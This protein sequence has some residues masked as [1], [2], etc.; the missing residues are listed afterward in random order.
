MSIKV[1][2]TQGLWPKIRVDVSEVSEYVSGAGDDEPKGGVNITREKLL[3][4]A[5]AFK[6]SVVK[7]GCFCAQL[8]SDDELTSILL[9]AGRELANTFGVLCTCMTAV[10]LKGGKCL[11]AEV[12]ALGDDINKQ[13]DNLNMAALA[14]RASVSRICGALLERIQ[15]VKKMSL[16]P[17]SACRKIVIRNIKCM[18]D[19]QDELGSS[20]ERVK[21]GKK[22]EG[23]VP[24]LVDDE[25]DVLDFDGDDDLFL[26][27][28][29][30]E[31][32][33]A[34]EGLVGDMKRLA[35]SAADDIL[36]ERSRKVSS[37]IDEIVVAI[38]TGS[39]D[40]E[41]FDDLFDALEREGCGERMGK[42]REIV[43]R[44]MISK[45]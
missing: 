28:S 8:Q 21:E 7:F 22:T 35:V 23:E 20:L 15:R 36:A 39:D 24:E 12:A 11:T 25:D 6:R 42:V 37:K 32:I 38:T 30:E 41:E 16:E 26:V 1:I 14:N 43:R 2:D 5:D 17:S 13:V 45:A 44:E 19:A 29:A 4:E 3:Q 9:P 40:E 27:E 10:A 31:L 34:I 33:G 18:Q